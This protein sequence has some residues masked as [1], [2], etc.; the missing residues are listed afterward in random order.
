[1]RGKKLEQNNTFREL[2]EHFQEND[3]KSI[4]GFGHQDDTSQASKVEYK[5][6]SEFWPKDRKVNRK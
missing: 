3:E 6:D 5:E 1:M 2:I 4:V